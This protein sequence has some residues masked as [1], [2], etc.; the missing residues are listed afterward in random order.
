MPTAGGIMG[1]T[2]LEQ[3]ARFIGT[4]IT[5]YPTTGGQA[6]VG[7]TGILVCV[8]PCFI[9]LITCIGPAPCCP[10]GSACTCGRI[11]GGFGSGFGYGNVTG[12]PF[13]NN[14]GSVTVIPLDRIA[15]YVHN[16]V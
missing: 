14:V 10:L 7:I 8:D 6:G 11:G 13:I 16:A 9:K 12:G 15:A 1:G 3:L 5:I 2:L 4:T